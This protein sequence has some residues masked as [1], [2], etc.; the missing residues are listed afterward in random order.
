MKIVI[1]NTKFDFNI[2]AR[3]LKTKHKD[4]CPT[5][6][7][8]KLGDMWEDIQPY[9]F[10]EIA[11][12]FSNIEERRIAIGC[13]GIEEIAKQVNPK[14]VCKQTLK[15]TTTWINSKGQIETIDFEDT[16]EL[17]RVKADVL[18]G[19]QER[20]WLGFNTDLSFVKFKDT[21]TDREY[22]IWID[23]QEVYSTN[24]TREDN[25]WYSSSDDYVSMINPIQAI[26]WTIQT[27]VPKGNIDK[28]VRQGDCILIKK[29]ESDVMPSP[30]R[31]LTEKEY[32]EL[33]VLE[34]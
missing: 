20:K 1:S 33:L 12:T 25:R 30:I 21:S 17:Y 6:A 31:H 34:S 32:R 7:E 19:T 3:L 29:K 5:F 23:A 10:K 9:T 24:D 18:N 28:I 15:K 2:G 14:L 8:D 26:A 13:L 4:T 27:Q 11:Q 22:F 16:Y